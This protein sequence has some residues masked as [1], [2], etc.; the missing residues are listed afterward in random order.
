M[1]S[2]TLV[3]NIICSKIN[4]H[5]AA[6]EQTIIYRQLFAGHGGLSANKKEGQN[7]SNYDIHYFSLQLS[8]SNFKKS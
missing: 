3:E 1:V 8:A 5:D 6:R 7:E 2:V 4:L